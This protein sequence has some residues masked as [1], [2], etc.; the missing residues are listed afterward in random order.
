M[1]Q[2]AFGENGMTTPHMTA[3]QTKQL[4]SP[5]HSAEIVRQRVTSKFGEQLLWLLLC[6]M[7][8][9]NLL[10]QANAGPFSFSGLG[11]LPGGN[12]YSAANGVSADGSVVVGD[13]RSSS[14]RELSLIHI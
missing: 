10:P 11:D 4:F 14:G 6:G 3:R 13:S 8:L 7:L 9:V 5:R 1:Q 12:V 2:I